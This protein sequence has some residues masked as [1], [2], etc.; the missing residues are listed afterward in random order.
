M[1][2]SGSSALLVLPGA[3]GPAV[4]ASLLSFDE[5]EYDTKH[6]HH[7]APAPPLSDFV[8]G[9]RRAEVG[10]GSGAAVVVPGSAVLLSLPAARGRLGGWVGPDID[11][12][13]GN[14]SA[15]SGG[16]SSGASSVLA[17]AAAAPIGDAAAPEAAAPAGPSPPAAAARG[18]S[19]SSEAG[20]D[21]GAI[22]AGVNQDTLPTARRGVVWADELGLELV[23]VRLAPCN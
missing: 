17:P 5:Q 21:G 4:S 1:E 7:H 20:S 16:G 15:N 18:S 3:V 11:G 14:N 13:D 19:S 12:G 10:A 23:Q 8:F 22:L 6:F 2:L 9:R